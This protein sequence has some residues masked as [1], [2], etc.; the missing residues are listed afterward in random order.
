MSAPVDQW[1]DARLLKQRI[2]VI[3]VG[4]R[5]FLHMS[6]LHNYIVVHV[7]FSQIS[8][9]NQLQVI[10]CRKIS[11]MRKFSMTTCVS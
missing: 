4:E 5:G 9:D 1:T 8:I 6:I 7:N 3:L 2:L 10:H 11:L